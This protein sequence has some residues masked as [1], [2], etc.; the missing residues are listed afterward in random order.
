MP[1]RKVRRKTRKK[2]RRKTRKKVRRKTGRKHKMMN[3]EIYNTGSYQYDDILD[4]KDIYLQQRILNKLHTYNI[5]D[6]DENEI[7]KDIDKDKDI[8]IYID[9]KRLQF[10]IDEIDNNIPIY[11]VYIKRIQIWTRP[12]TP[13][14][15]KYIVMNG[16]HRITASVIRGFTKIPVLYV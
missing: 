2:V 8:V 11:P 16:N 3:Q 13:N 12:H 4:I 7:D 9:T 1:T 6:Y 15:Y 5:H 14:R 10:V